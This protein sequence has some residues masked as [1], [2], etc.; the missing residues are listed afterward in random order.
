MNF[1]KIKSALIK[2][3][4]NK[5]KSG[6]LVV[7]ILGVLLIIFSGLFSDSKGNEIINTDSENNP[8]YYENL[9]CQKIEKIV[10]DMLGGGKVSVIVT[11]ENGTEYVYA[12]EIK[13]DTEKSED[14]SNSKT[15]ES[16]SVQESFLIVKDSVGNE[17]ALVIKEKMPTVR[18]VAVVC[19][20]GE[21]ANVS[22]AVKKAI[23]AVLDVKEENICVIG[24]YK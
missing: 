16:G 1:E 8:T 14:L 4:D 17:S 6:L 10:S 11:L 24:R 7:G 13:N 3:K 12:N 15:E 2:F 19:D 18:G 23:I 5:K 21:T 20:G 9:I 22:N